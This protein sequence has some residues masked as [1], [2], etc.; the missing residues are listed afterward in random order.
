MGH[1]TTTTVT[2]EGFAESCETRPFLMKDH[3]AIHLMMPMPNSLNDRVG[4][5][6]GV[7]TRSPL[8][9]FPGS[10]AM[11]ASDCLRIPDPE[12]AILDSGSVTYAAPSSNI[13]PPT[14]T[15]SVALG[16]EAEIAATMVRGRAA[17][18]DTNADLKEGV[19]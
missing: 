8:V 1:N 5:Y 16:A 7:I 9:S 2:S 6:S 4:H 19:P 17:T 18:H 14:P 11:V 10:C 3:R 12:K 13:G 15:Y